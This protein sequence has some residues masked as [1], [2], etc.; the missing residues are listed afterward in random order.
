M[1]CFISQKSSVRKKTCSESFIFNSTVFINL[2]E[3]SY[4]YLLIDPAFRDCTIEKIESVTQDTNL[5]TV[6][7]PKGCRMKVPAGYHVHL[8]HTIQG[9]SKVYME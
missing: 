3:A 6:C 1:F 9:T 8:K 4:C 5:Y 2:S 7:L